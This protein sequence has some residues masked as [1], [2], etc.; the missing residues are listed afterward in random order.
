MSDTP[1]IGFCAR[2][3]NF[4]DLPRSQKADGP[5]ELF[6]LDTGSFVIYINYTV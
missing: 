4:S 5:L 1:L 6:T 3:L 2:K